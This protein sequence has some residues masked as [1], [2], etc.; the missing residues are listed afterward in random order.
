MMTDIVIKK[1]LDIFKNFIRD[2]RLNK[3]E[4]QER[5]MEWCLDREHSTDI[6]GGIIGDE[7]GLGKTIVSLGLIVSNLKQ[8]T[9]VVLPTA[10]MPQWKSKIE[11][12]LGIEPLVYYGNSRSKIADDAKDS[13]IV[14][15]TYGVISRI[16][17]KYGKIK[18]EDT[19]LHNIEWDRIIF[20]ESHHLRNSNHR[21]D[22]SLHLKS[23]IKWCLTGT[24]IQNRKRDI[25]M[26]FHIVGFEY[27]YIKQHIQ[28]LIDTVLLRRKMQDV[29]LSLPPINS[30]TIIVDW[31]FEEKIIRD[32]LNNN[33][34][35]GVC[36]IDDEPIGTIYKSSDISYYSNLISNI[37]GDPQNR[38]TIYLRARQLCISPVLFRKKI[39]ELIC[40]GELD[41]TYRRLYSCSSKLYTVSNTIVENKMNSNRKI[42]FCHFIEEINQ[43]YEMIVDNDDMDKYDDTQVA[44]YSGSLSLEERQEILENDSIEVLI[45]QIQTGCEGLNLQQYSDIYMVSPHWNPALE[46]QAVARCHRQGQLKETN[47]YRFI[48]KGSANLDGYIRDTQYEKR[49]N[50]EIV[51]PLFEQELITQ[52]NS[53]SI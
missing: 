13:F 22:C 32:L 51:E 18:K 40:V 38:L 43:L 29:G 11:S 14:L 49:K 41:S 42:V 17:T 19:I 37:C 24:P 36:K 12:I 28:E 4:Y 2:A 16:T 6:R 7:M 3:A 9:L 15:T 5:A 23:D 44:I 34:D 1:Q 33:I 46:D 21:H 26:L 52:F 35:S 48:M 50:M 8:R 45:M 31:S 47:V 39:E 10:L 25:H 53:L 27:K 30:K 20:D